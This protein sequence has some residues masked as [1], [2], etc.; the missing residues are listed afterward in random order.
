MVFKEDSRAIY[1]FEAAT[2]N[3]TILDSFEKVAEIVKTIKDKKD[4]LT[5]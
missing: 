3:V 5:Q 2:R 4:P 1:R